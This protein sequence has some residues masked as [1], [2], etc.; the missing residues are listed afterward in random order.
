[1]APEPTPRPKPP[2]RR[3]PF[4][5]PLSP[6]YFGAL[7][8]GLLIAAQLATS[9]YTTGKELSYSEF[10][11]L[12]AQGQVV[13]V[14]LSEENIRGTYQDGT[15]QPVEFTAVRVEEPK[16]AEQLQ[17]RKVKFTG[18]VQTRWVTEVLGWIFPVIL[19]VVL[20]TVFFRRMGG[21]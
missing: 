18:E 21:A 17:E 5:R 19:I 14:H 7:L 8:F 12:L 16:L 10:K 15:G 6:L 9:L 13:E 4:R 1:M 2:V 20:W 3:S 11:S